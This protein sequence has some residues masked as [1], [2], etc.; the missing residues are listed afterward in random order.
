MNYIR[1]NLE[2]IEFE[3]TIVTA[4][5][6]SGDIPDGSDPNNGVPNTGVNNP[7]LWED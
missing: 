7:N 5:Y 1:P 4:L 2:I 6:A 3:E